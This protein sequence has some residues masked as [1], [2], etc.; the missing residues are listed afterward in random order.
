MHLNTL[1]RKVYNYGSAQQTQLDSNSAIMI[2]SKISPPAG[3]IRWLVPQFIRYIEYRSF[4]EAH[5][6]CL[7]FESA[8]F[9]LALENELTHELHHTKKLSPCF[10]GRCRTSSIA[11]CIEQHTSEGSLP[12]TVLCVT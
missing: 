2:N 3:T 11:G 1:R 5:G 9:L 12:S 6:L 8:R 7:L 4:S 10:N